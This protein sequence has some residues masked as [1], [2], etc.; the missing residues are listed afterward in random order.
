MPTDIAPAILA[1]ALLVLGASF[2]LQS[3]PWLSLV[4]HI[5]AKPEQFFW[6]A[7][8]ELLA[9]LLLAMSYNRWDTTWPT[10]TTLFGWLMALEGSLFLVAPSVFVRFN[11]LGDDFIRNYL[12]IGGAI[13]LLLGALLGRFALGN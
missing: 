6:V 1:I 9:G 7:I 10:F 3:G 4:R 2:L 11:R 12:K 13:L 5:F 8:I